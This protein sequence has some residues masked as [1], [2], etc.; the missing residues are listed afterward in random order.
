[1]IVLCAAPNALAQQTP[2]QADLM[3]KGSIEMWLGGILM[4]AGRL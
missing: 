2:Q 3:R 1:L 4:G